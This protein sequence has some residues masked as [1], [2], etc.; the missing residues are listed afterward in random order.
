VRL[1]SIEDPSCLLFAGRSVLY[2]L[3]IDE[4]GGFDRDLEY[5]VFGGLS[6][7]EADLNDLKARVDAVMAYYL[8]THNRSLE[9]HA[10][11]M[12]TGS[13]HWRKIPQDVRHG[14]LRAVVELIGNYE[15]AS[16][17]RYG[18]FAVARAP[19]AVPLASPIERSIQELLYHFAS[20][21]R[22]PEPANG[23]V[24][25]DEARHEQV[26]QPLVSKWRD[27]GDA[28]R[29]WRLRPLR[30]VVEVPLF[31]DSG[32]TR[33]LQLADIVAHIVFLYY[34]R[35][36]ETWIGPLLR[37]FFTDGGVMHGLTHLTPDFRICSCPACI[38]RVTRDRLR[39]QGAGRWQP[40]TDA[41]IP[42]F[43]EYIEEVAELRLSAEQPEA[44]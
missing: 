22:D 42:P 41:A 37:A 5:G 26:I 19:F 12:R 23:I 4:S 17:N 35:K 6:V 21:L 25:C 15:S 8:D 34:E 10:S 43:D 20:S 14:L 36:D 2:L 44:G 24:I 9:L 40:A 13:R 28:R 3:Y 27:E 29:F 31:A 11:D 18:L 1:A 33:L 39:R 7:H 30:A 38:S 16:G 32:V